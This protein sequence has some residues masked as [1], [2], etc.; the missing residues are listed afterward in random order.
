MKNSMLCKNFFIM[1]RNVLKYNYI[2]GAIIEMGS[3]L[4]KTG[5]VFIAA[6]TGMF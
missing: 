5:F 4:P 1:I 6:Q 2:K 3:F